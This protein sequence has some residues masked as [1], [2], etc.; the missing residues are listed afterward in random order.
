MG[1]KHILQV[2]FGIRIE[3]LTTNGLF[4]KK[5][6]KSAQKDFLRKSLQKVPKRT[7]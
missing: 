7:F 1:L 2:E 3:R 5:S 4:K 6:A